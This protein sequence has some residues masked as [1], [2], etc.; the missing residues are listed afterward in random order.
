MRTLL[1]VDHARVDAL[2]R[3]IAALGRL[4]D[5]AEEPAEVELPG[6]LLTDFYLVL[7][8]ICHQTTPV[9]GPQVRGELGGHELRGWD[10][11]RQRFL[12]VVQSDPAWVRRERLVTLTSE[13][14][15]SAFAD[16]VGVSTLSDPP[17]RARLLNDLGRTMIDVGYERAQDLY[18]ASE[19]FLDRIEP[20]GL[21]QRLSAFR[22][23]SDPVRKK[24]LFLLAL[25]QN[26]GVWQYRD[27]DRLGTPVDYH[28]V[29]GHLRL[30]TVVITDE[31]LLRKVTS[32]SLVTAEEDIEIRRA[33][34]DAIMDLSVRTGHTPAQ[35]HY[36]FWNVFRSCCRRDAT[37]CSSCTAGCCLPERYALLKRATGDHCLFASVC[38]SVSL[39]AKL[40]EHRVV[41]DYY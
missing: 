8:A 3:L 22:A 29:R 20:P 36:L 31:G 26:H 13:D 6:L 16:D 35:L 40:T 33:V 41:T 24:V 27:P 34:Y 25:L 28:E 32:S 37:H 39:G 1:V 9:G 4:P 7:V 15:V 38:A 5:D 10:Y 14:I 23:Y 17:G 19:G 12:R 18:E 21:F 30:G 11:L 2:G